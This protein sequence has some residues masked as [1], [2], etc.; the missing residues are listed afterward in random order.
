MA[1]GGWERRLSNAHKPL[2]FIGLS[3]FTISS[4]PGCMGRHTPFDFGALQ[5]RDTKQVP[6]WPHRGWPACGPSSRVGATGAVNDPAEFHGDVVN[7]LRRTVRESEEAA[8][9]RA[10]RRALR[11]RNS[12]F[13]SSWAALC[14]PQGGNSLRI[15]S[16]PQAASFRRIYTWS[17]RRCAF[18]SRPTGSLLEQGP[19]AFGTCRSEDARLKEASD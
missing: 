18:P 12:F 19:C 2:R 14:L 1:S 6:K 15:L 10:E 3:H 7:P 17:I 5:R 16:D 9:R 13:E 8:A 11:R 4:F